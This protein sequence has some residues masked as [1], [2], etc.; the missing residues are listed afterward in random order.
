ME[1]IQPILVEQDL[2][3]V[4]DLHLQS[5]HDD[6]AAAFIRGLERDINAGDVLIL[7]GDVFDAFAGTKKVYLDRYEPVLA[8]VR[9][10]CAKGVR[11]HVLE[12]NHDIHLGN[13]VASL[14]NA[15]L[16][17]G[18]VLMEWGRRRVWIEHGDEVNA[19]DY[20]Y[21]A[22]RMLFRS[23]LMKAWVNFSP[24][25]AFDAFARFSS[26]SSRGAN[27][28]L[29]EQLPAS[30]L[31]SLRRIYREAAYRRL[32]NGTDCV[33]FGHCHDLDEVRFTVGERQVQY[34]NMGFPPVHGTILRGRAGGEFIERHALRV[35]G[36][37]S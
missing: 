31:A 35:R 12:G 25:R 27:P 15:R 13:W 8:A 34:I 10:A 32:L 16:H 3:I 17:P 33:V 37:K 5:G 21:R 7:A 29:P 19:A 28:W 24:D 11:L 6:T 18:G 36:A 26:R 2:W 1:E 9:E 22:L 30:Q 4:S 23:P 14:P 20:G